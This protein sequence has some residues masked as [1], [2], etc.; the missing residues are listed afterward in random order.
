MLGRLL[1]R[2]VGLSNLLENLLGPFLGPLGRLGALLGTSW[3]TLGSL[4]G[5]QG[6]A[7]G[8]RSQLVPSGVPGTP[9]SASDSLPGTLQKL[10]GGTSRAFRGSAGH[11]TLSTTHAWVQGLLWDMV[12]DTSK[13]PKLYLAHGHLAGLR[14]LFDTWPAGVGQTLPGP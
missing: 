1:G 8:P 5:P 10:P 12:M 6:A 11:K 2:F 4:E 7:G 9:Q 3:A 13:G 14:I